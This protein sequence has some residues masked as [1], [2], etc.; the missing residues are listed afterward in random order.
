[1]RHCML[2]SSVDVRKGL[3]NFIANRICIFVLN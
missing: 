1:L 2:E 3:V